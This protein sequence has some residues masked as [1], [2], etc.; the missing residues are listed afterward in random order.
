M[1]DSSHTSTLG[2]AT[3]SATLLSPAAI[4]AAI[5]DAMVAKAL[6]PRGTTFLL[7]IMAGAFIALGFIF[8]TSSQMGSSEFAWYGLTKTVGGLTFSVGLILVI[9]TG[10]DLFTS[11]TMTLVPLFRRHITVRE[12]AI[13]WLVVYIGNFVG[14]L[15]LAAIIFF[16]ATYEQGHGQ[17][18]VV[19][20]QVVSGKVTHS[21]IEAFLL[22]IMANLCV[23][24]A[25]FMATGAKSGVHKMLAVIG[26]IALFVASGFE[27]SVANMFLIP[28]GILIGGHGSDAFWASAAVAQAGVTPDITATINTSSFL[29]NNLIP[30]TLG[31]II[32][33]G[34]LVGLA[35]SFIYLRSSEKPAA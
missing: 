10:A 9:F 3:E 2:T 19:V 8:Y 7:A 29:I 35:Y 26:P 20:L 4:T 17:W 22:G 16:S 30:V 5:N 27:H 13:H 11:A 18:G 33:G 12:W 24:L 14:A 25:V 34:V 1:K 21:W 32:G 28:L 31:N 15:A 6:K 23:C